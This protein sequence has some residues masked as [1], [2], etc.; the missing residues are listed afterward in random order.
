[1]EEILTHDPCQNTYCKA[2][3]DDLVNR[4]G[5]TTLCPLCREFLHDQ[6]QL[7]YLDP[8]SYNDLGIAKERIEA[9][10]NRTTITRSHIVED[11]F[12]LARRIS[13]FCH[14]DESLVEAE[15]EREVAEMDA[16]ELKC[17]HTKYI[18]VDELDQK[19]QTL[20]FQEEDG[21]H[22][23]FWR[24]SGYGVRK[25]M[26]IH[27]RNICRGH[28]FFIPMRPT[29]RVI[30]SV[31]ALKELAG[32]DNFNATAAGG[33][34]LIGAPIPALEAGLIMQASVPEHRQGWIQYLDE[35]APW[36]ANEGTHYGLIRL[37]LGTAAPKSNGEADHE[38][39][40]FMVPWP[41]GD[42]SL[43]D[44]YGPTPDP[45]PCHFPGFAPSRPWISASF[46]AMGLEGGANTA[47]DHS[48]L[49]QARLR[50]QHNLK[51]AR[52]VYLQDLDEAV[53]WRPEWDARGY[54]AVSAL[55]REWYEQRT[56][57]TLTC[58]HCLRLRYPWIWG[59][60]FVRNHMNILGDILMHDAEMNLAVL[61]IVGLCTALNLTLTDSLLVEVVCIVVSLFLVGC[62]WTGCIRALRTR[63]FAEWKPIFWADI[64]WLWQGLWGRRHG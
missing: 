63:T 22:F 52:E 58:V 38:E 48:L 56:M 41:E 11:V 4:Q 36:M 17:G 50:E 16:L 31:D 30:E 54:V 7:P 64:L 6:E 39:E 55:M 53:G 51:W 32:E 25:F 43:E 21:S 1:M 15:I 10:S 28:V 42:K 37:R 59:V 8:D 40:L 45:A 24:W 13:A 47:A 62:M 29:I 57:E 14:K 20:N 12:D 33:T 23:Q 19:F 9:R 27:L 60:V 44:Y 34:Q 35:R 2:C 49:L 26:P 46:A 5:N 61:A 18:S 3:F